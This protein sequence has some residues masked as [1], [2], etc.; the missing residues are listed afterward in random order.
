MK[1]KNK[2][3]TIFF[4]YQEWMPKVGAGCYFSS[5]VKIIGRVEIEDEV[6]IWFNSVVRGD[7]AP[8]FIG[9]GTNIQDLSM[10]HVTE[11][12]PLTIGKFVSVGHHVVLHGARIEDSCLIG[13]GSII[14]DNV[15]VGRNCLV[16]AGSVLPPG[17]IYPPGM[18]IKGSPGRVERPLT[19]AEKKM[20]A[21]H[22]QTY[23]V[24]KNDYLKQESE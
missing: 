10:L 21:H 19:D 15:V 1:T 16:A 23:L 18:L 6:N 9:E 11:E 3:E 7:V 2:G 4:P 17:K 13:M 20:V 12:S 14:M 8:I 22:Y 5:G 24:Y